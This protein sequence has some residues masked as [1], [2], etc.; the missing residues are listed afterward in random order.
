MCE[1][2]PEVTPGLDDDGPR[3]RHANAEVVEVSGVEALTAVGIHH[4]LDFTDLERA[5]AKQTYDGFVTLYRTDAHEARSLLEVGDSP[6]DDALPVTESAAWT[7]LA[8]QLM[9]LD[10]MLNK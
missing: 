3:V 10:E 5:V 7:M 1:S 9:N 4:H 2:G 6:F 8:S